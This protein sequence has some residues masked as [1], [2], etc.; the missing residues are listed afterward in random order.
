MITVSPSQAKLNQSE[1]MRHH[2]ALV[3][4]S[5]N[6][7]THSLKLHNNSY[8][9]HYSF[10]KIISVDYPYFIFHDLQLKSLVAFPTIVILAT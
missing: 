9:V 3:V 4:C 2:Y 1:I 10:Y 8:Y 6:R 7:Y 5:K